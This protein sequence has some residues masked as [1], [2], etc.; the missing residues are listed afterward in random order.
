MKNLLKGYRMIEQQRCH[1]PSGAHRAFVSLGGS[2]GVGLYLMNI[3][4]GITVI[5]ILQTE[6]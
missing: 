1:I 2:L 4:D 5:K 6:T 3:H